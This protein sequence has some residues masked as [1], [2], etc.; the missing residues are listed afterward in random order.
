MDNIIFNLGIVPLGDELNIFRNLLLDLL[1][2][3]HITADIIVCCKRDR[4]IFYEKIFKNIVFLDD[5]YSEN[6]ETLI[7]NL[8]TRAL[9]TF[10]KEYQV[11]FACDMLLW[12]GIPMTNH[13]YENMLDMKFSITSDNIF[14]YSKINYYNNSNYPIEFK[15]MVTNI[16]YL[17]E[18]PAFNNEKFIVYHHRVKND[19]M[20]DQPDEKLKAILKLKEKYNIVICS[21]VDYSYLREPNVYTITELNEFASFIH[22]ENCIALI[23][24]WSGGGQIG[25]YCNNTKTIMFFDK[26]QIQVDRTE[27]S[28]KKYI[29]SENGFDFCHFTDSKK[30]IY[31]RKRI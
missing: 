14:N 10:G 1:Y 9:E 23:S 12:P 13:G 5:V 25:S 24:V 22:S 4:V 11:L 6:R 15:E 30:N 19:N 7:Q 29:D 26:T 2:K 27:D 31:K 28:L 3:K 18:L 8:K 17:D 20:W 16:N 21:H